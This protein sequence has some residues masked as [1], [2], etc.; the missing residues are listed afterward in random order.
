VAVDEIKFG[1][2]DLLA[3]LVV[4]LIDADLLIILTTTDGLRQP[5]SSGCSR[6]VAFLE[7]VTPA[8]L[9]LA[10]G[11]GSALSTGGMASK[12][13]AAHA[14]AKTGAAVVIA[15]GRQSGIIG[16]ILA[17][18]NTGTLIRPAADQR[19]EFL[20]GRKRWIAFFHKPQ[21][22]LVID[23][24]AR[25]AIER[26]GKSLLPIGIKKVDGEFETGAA[27][28]IKSLDQTLIARGLVSYS[29]RD[30]RLIQGRRTDAIAGILGA[31][32]YEEVIHRDNMAIMNA[33][34][35]QW[36]QQAEALLLPS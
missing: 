36:P 23:E 2:N 3:S 21:G 20:T 11:K 31:A 29:S 22:T 16:K 34:R 6:R 27:V 30:I 24:G 1:D 35:K 12:L 33:S 19:A 13:E 28:D 9:E 25:R 8:V 18:E 32:N 10:S 26:D 7:G 5:A 4:H 17:G 14:V 15:D